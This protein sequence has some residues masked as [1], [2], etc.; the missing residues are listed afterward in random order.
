MLRLKEFFGRDSYYRG[1]H[2]EWYVVYDYSRDSSTME[3]SNVRRIRQLYNIE[4][5]KD[6]KFPSDIKIERAS[7]WAVG[8][9]EYI[10]INPD[11]AE[12]VKIAE[13]IQENLS[14]YPVLSEDLYS[15]M[16]FEEYETWLEQAI[17]DYN[18]NHDIEFAY[19]KYHEQCIDLAYN[20]DEPYI[21][22]DD[23]ERIVQENE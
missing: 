1:I 8:W 21:D 7:H 17:N 18:L 4:A 3:L 6:D 23:L 2:G 22:S 10:I 20:R 11:N 15:N 14:N 9:I 13:E 19:D 12:F 16:Q 5:M